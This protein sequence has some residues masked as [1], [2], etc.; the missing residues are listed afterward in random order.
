MPTF[1]YRAIQHF[2][3][4]IIVLAV[5]YKLGDKLYN[6]ASKHFM[7][8]IMKEL[9]QMRKDGEKLQA[10][11]EER[12]KQLREDATDSDGDQV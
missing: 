3:K 6:W 5:K 10:K 8:W 2:F 11:I 9:T 12:N 7:T 4:Y 1:I